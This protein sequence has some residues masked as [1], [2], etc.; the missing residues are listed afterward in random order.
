MKPSQVGRRRRCREQRCSI[1]SN[2]VEASHPN[3]EQPGI[4]PLQVESETE[5]RINAGK[6]TGKDQNV[7]QAREFHTVLAS[8]QV[9]LPCAGPPPTPARSPPAHNRETQDGVEQTPGHAPG[10]YGVLSAMRAAKRVTSQA[11]CLRIA[12]ISGVLHVLMT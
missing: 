10:G 7:K 12:H 8:P 2:G 9:S 1:C 11:S 3:V 6:D 5:Q 4:A